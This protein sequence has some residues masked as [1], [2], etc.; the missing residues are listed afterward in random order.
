[1]E[2]ERLK[3]KIRDRHEIDSSLSIAIGENVLLKLPGIL[4]AIQAFWEKAMPS[5]PTDFARVKAHEF[6]VGD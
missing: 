1:M 5:E 2:H 4:L 6:C 3:M